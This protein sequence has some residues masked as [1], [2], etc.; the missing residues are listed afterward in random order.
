[1]VHRAHI[2]SS[3]NLFDPAL[4]S[5]HLEQGCPFLGA[6]TTRKYFVTVRVALRITSLDE[7]WEFHMNVRGNESGLFVVAVLE[8]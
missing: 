3:L 5:G 8:M 4:A 6:R 7:F 2:S 1:M